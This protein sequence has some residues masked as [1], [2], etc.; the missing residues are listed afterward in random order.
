MRVVRPSGAAMQGT[1]G[2]PPFYEAS[3][4]STSP[5]VHGSFNTATNDGKYAGY[6]Q[7]PSTPSPTGYT[8]YLYASWLAKGGVSAT[9]YTTLVAPTDGAP[10]GYSAPVDVLNGGIIATNKR[11]TVRLGADVASS[12]VV[13]AV[14]VGHGADLLTST[15]ERFVVRFN[16][17]YKT[18]STQ[19]YFKWNE[20]ALEDRVRLWVDNK[21]IIDQWTSLAVAAPTGGYLFDSSSGI[22]DIHAEFFRLEGETTAKSIDVQDGSAAG[23]YS[24]ITTDKLFFTE[25]LSGSP[26]AVTVST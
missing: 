25:K 5:T 6:Y 7:V 26:Y 21:L 13:T 14:N 8:H 1:R 19:R 10:T 22:Y 23:T 9:Y 18:S 11:F 3:A 16:G 12:S 24:T 4:I 17:M 20:I 15:V 2:T